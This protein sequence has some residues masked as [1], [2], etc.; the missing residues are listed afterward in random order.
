MTTATKIRRRSLWIDAHQGET[1]DCSPFG[2]IGTN[3]TDDYQGW[4]FTWPSDRAIITT[5]AERDAMLASLD[6][7]ET[8][9]N[10]PQIPYRW[11]R[12]KLES[13]LR[14]EFDLRKRD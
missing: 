14:R 4:F 2:F 9:T 3:D 13:Y 5:V 6:A 11:A 12:Q 1:D 10:E 8:C 7:D